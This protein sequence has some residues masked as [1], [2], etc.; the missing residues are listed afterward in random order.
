ML[1]IWGIRSVFRAKLKSSG[2]D[3]VVDAPFNGPLSV[4]ALKNDL[5]SWGVVVKKCSVDM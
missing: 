5:G 4:P 3:F 1:L 2:I